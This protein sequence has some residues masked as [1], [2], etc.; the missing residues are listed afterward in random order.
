MRC[1]AE[2]Q[3]AVMEEMQELRR[4]HEVR[5]PVPQRTHSRASSLTD[6]LPCA[7]SWRSTLCLVVLLS[8]LRWRA[9]GGRRCTWSSRPS[10]GCC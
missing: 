2:V 4:K 7:T 3:G 10:T 6:S 5:L 9:R 1:Q 8:W